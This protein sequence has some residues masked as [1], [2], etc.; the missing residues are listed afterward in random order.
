MKKSGKHDVVMTIEVFYERGGSLPGWFWCF[1]APH[2]NRF[3]AI[4]PFDTPE[5]ALAHAT[6]KP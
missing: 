4:G 6:S 1:G 5:A 2:R 3:G